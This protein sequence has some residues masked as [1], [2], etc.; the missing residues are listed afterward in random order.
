MNAPFKEKDN[1]QEAKAHTPGP[2]E[3][4]HSHERK[5]HLV[6]EVYKGREN[7]AS[8]HAYENADEA[9]ANARLIAA[10]PELLEALEALLRDIRVCVCGQDGKLTSINCPLHG[11]AAD[12]ARVAIKKARGE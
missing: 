10:A 5:G 1:P 11:A 7:L 8:I 3:L 2:W 9:E 6:T 4:A 12:R